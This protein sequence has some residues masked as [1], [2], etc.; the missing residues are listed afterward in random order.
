MPIRGNPGQPYECVAPLV[1]VHSG[2]R[3]VDLRFASAAVKQALGGIS[4]SDRPSA[5]KRK[6]RSVGGRAFTIRSIA[7]TG[8]IRTSLGVIVRIT[9]KPEDP[10]WV[11]DWQDAVPVD[12]NQEFSC[13][14][15]GAEF[16]H[17][18]SSVQRL[19]LVRGILSENRGNG[20]VSNVTKS[21]IDAH[22]VAK[23]GVLRQQKRTLDGCSEQAP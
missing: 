23:M 16:L 8:K 18:G 6:S 2:R 10:W 13:G 3:R 15:L 14:T 17:S 21:I 22:L 9:E 12:S 5:T 7:Q 20:L 19:F 4:G 11:L 1:T